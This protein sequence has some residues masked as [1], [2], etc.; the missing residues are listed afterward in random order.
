MLNEKIATA[1][2]AGK[3]WLDLQRETL[4]GSKFIKM[5]TN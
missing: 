2:L 5:L 3:T 1:I 4:N